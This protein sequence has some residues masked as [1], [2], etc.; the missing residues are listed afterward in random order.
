VSNSKDDTFKPSSPVTI[1]HQDFRGK[2]PRK[3]KGPMLKAPP[4]LDVS[5]LYEDLEI[6]CLDM[7]KG[8]T[9]GPILA[10]RLERTCLEVLAR[11]GLEGA[12]VE[13]QSGPRGT[14]V[15]IGLPG[16]KNTIKQLC[17]TIE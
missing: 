17:L 5:E 2:G 10:H 13:V 6:A 4:Q 14:Q 3:P 15:Q 16:P 1:R 11:N 8:D 7:M 12:R 9:F